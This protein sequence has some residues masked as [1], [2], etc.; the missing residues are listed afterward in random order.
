MQR[1]VRQSPSSPGGETFHERESWERENMEGGEGGREQKR[2]K[3][4]D[5][6]VT[7]VNPRLSRVL[8]AKI[9]PDV[10][11]VATRVVRRARIRLARLCKTL[12]TTMLGKRPLYSLTRIFREPR[13]SSQ[14][15]ILV[16]NA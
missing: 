13:S 15:D 16:V 12:S 1:Y 11:L 7:F 10:S 14:P 6:F 5:K 4:A 8:L 3:I 9:C 2:W